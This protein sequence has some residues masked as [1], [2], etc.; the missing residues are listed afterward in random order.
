TH[1]RLIP[2][3]LPLDALKCSHMPSLATVIVSLR[4]RDITHPELCRSPR[5]ASPEN[6]AQRR[7]TDTNRLQNVNSAYRPV[8]LIRPLVNPWERQAPAY[9]TP[10]S[11]V[12]ASSPMTSPQFRYVPMFALQFR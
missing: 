4:G 2:T 5:N 7:R 8:L 11:M 6:R 12:A 10:S 9:R 1:S 3:W